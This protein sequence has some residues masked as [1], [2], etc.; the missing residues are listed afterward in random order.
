MHLEPRLINPEVKSESWLEELKEREGTEW[1]N[2]FDA[3]IGISHK[4]LD[5][6]QLETPIRAFP[7]SELAFEDNKTRQE[8]WSISEW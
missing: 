7:G 4:R 1:N 2:L 8:A 3:R 5:R 6:H